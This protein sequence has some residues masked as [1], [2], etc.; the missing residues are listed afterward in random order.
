MRTPLTPLRAFLGLL[1]LWL[2]VPGAAPAQDSAARVFSDAPAAQ[3]IA[4]PNAD[5]DAYGV[6]HFRRV[7]TLERKP[8]RFVVHVS[9]DNRYRFFVNERPIANGPQRSDLAHWRYETLDLAPFLRAGDNVLA[10]QVWN[11]GPNRPVA[12]FSHRTAFLIQGDSAAESVAN[13]GRSWKMFSNSGYAAVPVVGPA[14]GGYYAAPPGE[15][16]DAAR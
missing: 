12:Q 14:T 11:W 9:A 7:L 6:F 15:S 10:A 5:G 13:T 3:W 1:S 2:F 4:P 16:L 8:E